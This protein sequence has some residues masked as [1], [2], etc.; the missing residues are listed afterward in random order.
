[1]R[2]SSLY[3]T[4]GDFNGFQRLWI[5]HHHQV[6]KLIFVCFLNT[7]SSLGKQEDPVISHDCFLLRFFKSFFLCKIPDGSSP[8]V[9]SNTTLT[10]NVRQKRMSSWFLF[11]EEIIWKT[12]SSEDFEAPPTAFL[13]GLTITVNGWIYGKLVNL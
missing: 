8:N 7:T 12:K 9:K 11:V 2:K 4:F 10:T 3:R 5:R 1:M 13:T 6:T